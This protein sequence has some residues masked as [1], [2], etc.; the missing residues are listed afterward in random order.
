MKYNLF[1][2]RDLN[3]NRYILIPILLIE[4]N[5]IFQFLKSIFVCLAIRDGFEYLFKQNST[6]QDDLYHGI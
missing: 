1:F 4:V 3:L 6:I 5:S 2:L